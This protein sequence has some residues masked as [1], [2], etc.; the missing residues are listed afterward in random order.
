MQKLQS[1]MQKNGLDARIFSTAEE[2]KTHFLSEIAPGASVG[3][4]G[5]VT[6]QQMGLSQT[7]KEKG[8]SVHWHW[9]ET[10]PAAM[11]EARKLAFEADVYLLSAN[12]V[13]RG[14]ILL[15][16]DGTGNRVA[17]S[18]YGPKDVYFFVGRNKIVDTVD[19]AIARLY[20]VATPLN[21][22]RLGFKKEDKRHHSV[23]V[24]LDRPTI[25]KKIHVCLIDQDLGY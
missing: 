18:F 23:I 24:L 16:A 10:G 8:H 14:G 1:I 9:E 21:A 19:D 3:I 25:G 6:V 2:A 12:A 20:N 15:N 5:S 22:E 17:A 13:T 7:L 4:G 11:N